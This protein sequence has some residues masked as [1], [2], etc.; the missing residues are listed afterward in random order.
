MLIARIGRYN[1]DPDPF[2]VER[3]ARVNL[4]DKVLKSV[5][6]IGIKKDG[7]FQPR[8]TAF[9]VSY[10][11]DQH[12]FDH[13]VTAE[14][15]IAGLLTGGHDIWLRVNLKNGDGGEVRLDGPGAFRFHP[16][17]NERTD[18]AVCPFS[19]NA[20]GNDATGETLSADTV[21]LVLDESE[22]GFL[23]TEEF[24][25]QSMGLGGQIAI[26]GLFRSHY[27]K[28]R[29]I[30][31][32]R[33]GNISALP[34]EPV[35]TRYAGYLSAYLIEARSIAGLSGSPVFALSDYATVLANNL[36]GGAVKQMAAL[37]GLM[38]GNFDIP[39]LNEDVVADEDAPTRSVH[40]GIGVV[41]PVSKILET[42]RHP[43]LTDMRK[44]RVERLR[45]TGAT[46]D[47]SSDDN[48]VVSPPAS[49]A[50]PKH[51]EDFKRLLDAAAR[52]PPQ[53]D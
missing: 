1:D 51:R 45:K 18:V 43:E 21:S 16:N 33:V 7:R 36:R 22:R 12:K 8:A 53:E 9:F 44:A 23:P 26:V 46:A 48:V 30:P 42:I 32:V 6:F 47:V 17:E 5:A 50:N 14:H 29:N 39:N 34:G 35:W 19:P 4:S 13:L 40:T 31:I 3:D 24:A 27:G 10:E 49:D 15:V 25:K 11:E 41:I 52:K 2:F 28:N 37:V 20:L 38:H